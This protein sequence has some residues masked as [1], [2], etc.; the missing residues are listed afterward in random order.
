MAYIERNKRTILSVIDTAIARLEKI[1]AEIR[2]FDSAK[3]V[4]DLTASQQGQAQ[5]R[6]GV[7]VSAVAAEMAKL[8]TLNDA[9]E[10]LDVDLLKLVAMPNLTGL[11]EAQAQSTLEERGFTDIREVE[12]YNV[13]PAGTLIAQRPD[14]DDEVSRSNRVRYTISLGVEAA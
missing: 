14:A 5:V 8:T 3:S 9:T 7:W 10:A 12:E 11:T 6:I 4:Y 1:R 2:A 13:A